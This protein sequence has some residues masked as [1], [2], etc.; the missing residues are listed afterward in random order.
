MTLLFTLLLLVAIPFTEGMLKPLMMIN[1][2]AV[3]IFCVCST[4]YIK[5]SRLN[6]SRKVTLL[7]IQLAAF[8]LVGIG[9]LKYLA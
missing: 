2:I 7:S 9:W 6:M 3:T 8:A 4:Y 5:L 1:L